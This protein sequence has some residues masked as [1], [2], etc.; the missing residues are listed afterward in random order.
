M[1]QNEYKVIPYLDIV[2]LLVIL[3]LVGYDSV[4]KKV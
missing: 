4:G 2:I 3:V 1:R